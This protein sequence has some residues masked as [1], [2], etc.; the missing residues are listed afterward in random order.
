MSVW[1]SCLLS[2]AQALDHIRS[3]SFYGTLV[4]TDVRIAVE[5]DSMAEG[6]A[7]GY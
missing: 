5:H 4:G 1:V 2:A 6:R 3:L 7:W